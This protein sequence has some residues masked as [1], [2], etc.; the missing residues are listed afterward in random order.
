MTN[1]PDELVPFPKRA[2]TEY[3]VL[4]RHSPS[5]PWSIREGDQPH[6]TLKDAE[7]AIDFEREHD[8]YQIARFN[9]QYL[10]DLQGIPS[11]A[12]NGRKLR[13]EAEKREYKVFARKVGAL[14]AVD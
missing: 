9:D 2:H 11:M 8:K 5:K 12:A 3:W 4:L 10:R 7:R 14:T 1:T 13:K 6:T